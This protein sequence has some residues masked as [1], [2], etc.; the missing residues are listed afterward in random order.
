MAN[1]NTSEIIMSFL[2]WLRKI[3]CP[4]HWAYVQREVICG[5]IMARHNCMRCGKSRYVLYDQHQS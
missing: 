1:Y 3:G 4:H 2:L 5:H